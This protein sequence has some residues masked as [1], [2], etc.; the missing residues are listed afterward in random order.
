MAAR[1]LSRLSGGP[2]VPASRCMRTEAPEK[3]SCAGHLVGLMLHA[4]P[5]GLQQACQVLP[6][7]LQAGACAQQLQRKRAVLAISRA[8]CCTL[9][10]R[11]AASLSG[12]LLEPASRLEGREAPESCAGCQLGLMLHARTEGLQQACQVLPWCLQAGACAQQL[13]RKRAVLAISRAWCCTLAHRPAASLSGGL[14]EPAS[15]LEG[16]EAPESCAGCQLGLM[17][18][19]RPEGLQQACQVLPKC[20]Q[21]GACAQ[22]LHR[23]R[24]VLAFSRAWCCTLAQRAS[25]KPV[26]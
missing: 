12:G 5:E 8:W 10:H 7:C 13:Q 11:P 21:A 18:H 4:R 1:S 15:R 16:R 22:Q 17:L 3:E 6:K 26:R 19:A 2:L 14:L 24:A 25:S 20:L 23:K 9:A